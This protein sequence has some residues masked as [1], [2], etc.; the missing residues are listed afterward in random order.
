[1][2][3]L[4]LSESAPGCHIDGGTDESRREWAEIRRI[5]E[6]NQVR[7]STKVAEVLGVLQRRNNTTLVSLSLS[8][9]MLYDDAIAALSTYLLSGNTLLKQLFLTQT[10]LSD[11]RMRLLTEGLANVQTLEV[12]C[13]AGNPLLDD[14]ACEVASVVQNSPSLKEVMILNCGVGN[15]GAIALGEAMSKSKTLE[16]LD[17]AH[18]SNIS[19]H[20][21]LTL[22]DGLV[23]SKTM[24][25]LD[26]S[27]STHR[28]V[29][30]QRWLKIMD[31]NP[32]DV[33]IRTNEYT[34]VR[35]IAFTR[36]AQRVRVLVLVACGSPEVKRFVQRDGDRAVLTR[37]VRNLIG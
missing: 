13:L 15:A 6:D 23:K 1:M 2:I 30:R 16:K 33:E 4:N 12:I 22:E 19:M 34:M 24:R 20:G 3:S 37:V 28:F 17:L 26:V 11:T 8:M 25:V 18:N 31:L 9:T 27:Y 10:R 35:A 14:G 21:F 5:M 36:R 32:R 29:D 7:H